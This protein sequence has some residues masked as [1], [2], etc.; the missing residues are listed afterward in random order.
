MA[1]RF[2]FRKLASHLSSKSTT[3]LFPGAAEASRNFNTLPTTGL[4]SVHHTNNRVI[5]TYACVRGA[6]TNALFST[7]AKVDRLA[8]TSDFTP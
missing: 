6:N 3:R 4:S 8:A 1:G 5:N 2:V 7:T